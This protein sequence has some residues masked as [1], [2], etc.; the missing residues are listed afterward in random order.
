MNRTQRVKITDRYSTALPVSSGSALGR[1]TSVSHQLE[2]P[3][4]HVFFKVV[5]KPRFKR[6]FFRKKV[7]FF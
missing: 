7:V 2:M 3:K 1:T 4:K 6:V 5:L